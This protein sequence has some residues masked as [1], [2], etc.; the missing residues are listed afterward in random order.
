V[1]VLGKIK[2]GLVSGV[3][4]LLLFVAL[5][6]VLSNVRLVRGSGIPRTWTVDDDGPADFHTIQEAISAASVS[7]TVFVK[8]GTYHE[9]VVVNKTLSIV[10]EVR[11]T[12]IV[13]GSGTGTVFTVTQND[14]TITGFTMQ[15]SSMDWPNA[16][17]LLNGSRRNIIRNNI[18]NTEHGIGLRYGTSGNMI[19]GNSITSRV[20]AVFYCENGY[21]YENN[22][23]VNNVM[24]SEDGIALSGAYYDN[25]TGNY[26]IGIDFSGGGYYENGIKI[27]G[28][29][30]NIIAGNIVSH[31]GWEKGGIALWSNNDT[32]S[33]NIIENYQE[34]GIGIWGSGSIIVGNNLTN[35]LTITYQRGI[36]LYGGSSNIVV[37][38]TLANNAYGIS[39]SSS[40]NV[41]YDNNFINNM[42]Q[43]YQ[44]TSCN[45]TWDYGYPSGGNYWSD[46]TGDDLD[47]DGIGDSWHEINENNTDHYPLMGMFSSFDTS[48]GYAVDFVSNSSISNFSFNLSPIEVYLPEAILAFNVSGEADTEGFLRICIPKMLINGS[49]VIMFDDEIITNTTYPQV[50]ELPCSNETY[51]YLYINY[52]HSKHRLEVSGTTTIPEFPS[53]LILSLFMIAIMLVIIVSKR[54]RTLILDRG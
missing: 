14:V 3:W 54:K 45:N 37:G 22:S 49:Y 12:T 39:L 1:K 35:P 19:N 40:N 9:H 50:R 24:R 20:V 41:I 52:T 23:V 26:L 13:D 33:G 42:I 28:G 31:V 32:V 7:D 21:A 34:I 17:V 15:N 6:G 4:V 16:A 44:Y 46:Y 27:F 51:E 25:I 53:F 10:G 36:H 11:D 47:Y 5:S 18:I 38:N 2:A 43:V 8:N 29:A 48:Y 30:S